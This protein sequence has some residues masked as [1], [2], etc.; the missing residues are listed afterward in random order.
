MLRCRWGFRFALALAGAV[1]VGCSGSATQSGALAPYDA[2]PLSVR[3]LVLAESEAGNPREIHLFFPERSGDYPLLQFQHGFTSDVDSYTSL[4]TRLAGY[5]F[6]VVAP[7]MYV[8][9]PSS[10]P[11]VVEETVAAV[12]VLNWAQAN[13]NGVLA[14]R[15][16][17][18]S[19]VRARNADTGLLGHSRGGQ[20]AW[21][22]LF[23][24]PSQTR[25]RAIAGVDP[26]DG[27]A[28]PFPPGG[29]GE[30]VTDDAGAFSFDFPSLILGMGLGSQGVPGFECA[31]AVRNYSLFYNA[32]RRARYEMVASDFGHSDMTNGEEPGG[33]CFGALDGSREPV[34]VFVAGQLAAYFTTVL[35]GEDA[36]RWLRDPRLAPIATSGRFEE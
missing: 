29:T 10:A 32:S 25:A 18:A 16:P 6:V 7:Q 26:V 19:P 34:R 24:H 2:P 8:S 20:I 5:G 28:P 1:L 27:D 14:A 9:D 23:D 36:R 11:T 33:V 15:L 13:L 30:L 12:D 22:M 31:P 4:L 17:A 3:H 35:K 21:R